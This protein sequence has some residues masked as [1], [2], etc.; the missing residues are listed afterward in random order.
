MYFWCD[1][2]TVY[3]KKSPESFKSSRMANM[4]PFPY[5]FKELEK[6]SFITLYDTYEAV[7]AEG[8]QQAQYNDNIK[9][10]IYW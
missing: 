2:I 4:S 5:F 8:Y 10:P 1:V 7:E 3:I 9:L 6:R